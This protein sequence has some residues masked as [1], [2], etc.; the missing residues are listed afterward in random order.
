MR[1]DRC[2]KAQGQM[3]RWYWEHVWNA[4]ESDPESATERCPEYVEIKGNK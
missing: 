2:E 3:C 4:P 1:C